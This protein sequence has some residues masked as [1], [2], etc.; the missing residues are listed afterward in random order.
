MTGTTM[1]TKGPAPRP[2]P[3]EPRSYHFPAFERRTLTNGMRLVVA[4]V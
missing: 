1:P 2:S 3:T 4:P